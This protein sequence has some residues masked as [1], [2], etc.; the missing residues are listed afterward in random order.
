MGL[1]KPCVL[2]PL[3]RGRAG[4]SL[5]SRKRQVWQGP[6]GLVR[7]GSL[8]RLPWGISMADVG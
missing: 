3:G 5:R 7:G 6:D 4:A 8:F 2:P 1:G